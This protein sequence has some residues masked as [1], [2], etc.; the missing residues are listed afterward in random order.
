MG[1]KMEETDVPEE[2][3][4]IYES[5]T[6]EEFVKTMIDDAMR[7]IRDVLDQLGKDIGFDEVEDS[8]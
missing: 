8:E 1:D 2:V 3:V 6:R 4:S 5:G 7:K